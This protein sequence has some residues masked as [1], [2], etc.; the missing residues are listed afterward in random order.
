MLKTSISKTVEATRY[1]VELTYWRNKSLTKR[2][3]TRNLTQ[4]YRVFPKSLTK[5]IWRILKRPSSIQRRK[6]RI[7][8]SMVNNSNF[9]DHHHSSNLIWERFLSSSCKVH[10]H[11]WWLNK[12]SQD[13]LLHSLGHQCN[14]IWSSRWC[15]LHRWW[16]Q[17]HCLRRD[18]QEYRGNRGNRVIPC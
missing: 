5:W 15:H 1:K 16:F 14:S 7:I 18:L 17:D 13:L 9:R 8:H 11:Q 3:K 10:H 6:L 2:P 4:R 12:D